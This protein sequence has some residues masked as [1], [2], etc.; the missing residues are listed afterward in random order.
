MVSSNTL[1]HEVMADEMRGRVFSLLEI[2]MH[3]GFLMFM[4]LTSLA[5]EYIRKDLIL[6]VIGLIFSMIGFLK[7]VTGVME[8]K[9]VRQD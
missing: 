6:V 5:A 8:R 7:L 9:A 4:V 1:L 3:I 2:I